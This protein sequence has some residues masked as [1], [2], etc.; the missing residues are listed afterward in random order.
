MTKAFKIYVSDLLEEYYNVSSS[1]ANTSY[2]YLL[3][4]ELNFSV[5]FNYSIFILEITDA[6]SI[7]NFRGVPLNYNYTGK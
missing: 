1:Y 4:Y 6:N 7:I 3:S 2:N 5:S